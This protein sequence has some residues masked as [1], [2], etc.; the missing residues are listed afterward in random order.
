MMSSSSSSSSSS[1]TLF[2]LSFY[3][4]I[5]SICFFFISFCVRLSLPVSLSVSSHRR[6]FKETKDAA[7]GKTLGSRSWFW[8]QILVQISGLLRPDSSG[9]RSLCRFEFIA[10]RLA[11]GRSITVTTGSHQVFCVSGSRDK[12]SLTKIRRT[13][14]ERSLFLNSN[15]I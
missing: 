9:L 6:C 5:F 1:L 14:N 12:F 3:F 4:C 11:P 15:Q 8:I 13:Q 2:L 7:D 10:Y